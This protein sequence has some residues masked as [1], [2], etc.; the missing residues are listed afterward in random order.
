MNFL[1]S[2]KL[3]CRTDGW[4]QLIV[5]SSPLQELVPHD[6][7]WPEQPRAPKHSP[8]CRSLWIVFDSP[9]NWHIL[10]TIGKRF[11]TNLICEGETHGFETI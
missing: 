4:R 1:H 2:A 3:A 10:S 5:I 11:P 7:L 6:P 9:L 8:C